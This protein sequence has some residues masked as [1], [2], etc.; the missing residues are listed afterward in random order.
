MSRESKNPNTMKHYMT[1]NEVAELLMVSPVTVRQWAQKGKLEAMTTPGG[2]RRFSMEAI[3]KFA[4]EN[5]LTLNP[6]GSSGTRILIVDDDVSLATFLSEIL[7]Q[8]NSS[9]QVEIVH[10]GFSAGRMV[11]SFR[12]DILLL[13]LM[14]PQMNGFEVCHMVKQGKH[15]DTRVIAMSGFCSQENLDRILAEGAECCLKK[16][17]STSVLFTALGVEDQRSAG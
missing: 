15:H 11:E 1:P 12:P 2:H 6:G 16:P 14:M 4:E 5:N 7:T 17:F 9:L 8:R 10:D 13:D 3:E